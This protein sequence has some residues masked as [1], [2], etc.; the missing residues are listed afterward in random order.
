MYFGLVLEV[1]K[2]NDK[3]IGRTHH[4]CRKDNIKQ[5]KI[6][7]VNQL[8]QKLHQNNNNER[9]LYTSILNP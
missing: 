5:L 2:Y 3:F 4:K 7:K 8:E 1:I 9:I 6:T